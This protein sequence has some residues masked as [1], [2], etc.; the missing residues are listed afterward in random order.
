MTTTESSKKRAYPRKLVAIPMI[1]EAS[2]LTYYGV[3]R[4]SSVQGGKFVS[5]S[6]ILPEGGYFSFRICLNHL[7]TIY[8][9]ARVVS[10]HQNRM[11]AFMFDSMSNECFTLLESLDDSYGFA[12]Q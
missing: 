5:S 3:L 4:D 12:T 11:I 7:S 8:G 9:R 2:D 6:I 10:S 1:V